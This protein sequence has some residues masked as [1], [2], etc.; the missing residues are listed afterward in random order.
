MTPP[1]ATARRRGRTPSRR[2]QRCRRA[3][4][5]PCPPRRHR[6]AAAR[7]RRTTGPSARVVSRTARRRRHRPALVDHAGVRPH[8]L[9]AARRR[10]SAASSRGGFGSTGA[11]AFVRRLTAACSASP[12][13]SA[14]TGARSPSR[15]ASISTPSTASATG[16]SAPTTPSR[17][18][19]IE[20]DI[21]APT[22]E[23]DGMCRE[24]V[25]RADRRRAHAA[26]AAHPASRSGTGSRRAAKRG[27]PS[28]YGRFDLRYDGQGPAKLLEYNAD[29][30]TAVFETGVFQW[31]WL[32][33]AIARGRSLPEGRRPV[34]FAARAAD[35]RLEGDR[36]AAA[37]CISPA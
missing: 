26:D 31:K 1:A 36:Q 2:R 4:A 19:Q 9:V 6:A 17:C 24:L 21:E 13:T 28:L 25:A 20:R 16:T 14:P 35:R 10:G 18:E 22:A 23:L 7:R 29:T 37:G 12:A 5:E 32:E 11:L 3:G 27:D 8:G 34:Q 30:P 15:S 33:D